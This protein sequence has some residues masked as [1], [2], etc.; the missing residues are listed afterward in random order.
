[1]ASE[2]EHPEIPE[3]DAKSLTMNVRPDANGKVAVLPA[4]E[5]EEREFEQLLSGALTVPPVPRTLLK[6]LDREI[7]AEWGVSPE[8]VT[9]NQGLAGRAMSRLRRVSVMSVSVAAL[10]VMIGFSMLMEN[11]Q[12]R[13]WAGLVSRMMSQGI[14]ELRSAESVRW[15]N[16]QAGIV[17]QEEPGLSTLVDVDRK[18][19]TVW[20]TG[21]GHSVI[22]QDS[23]PGSGLSREALLVGFLSG[24]EDWRQF[25]AENQ[26]LRAV[27]EQWIARAEGGG[28]QLSVQFAG[29]R[30]HALKLNL[31]MP[32]PSALPL[33]SELIDNTRSTPESALLSYASES[34]SVLRRLVEQGTTEHE[35][36]RTALQ[37]EAPVATSDP[38]ENSTVAQHD[39]VP[40]MKNGLQIAAVPDGIRNAPGTLVAAR[41]LVSDPPAQWPAVRKVPAAPI[42]VEVEKLN[43]LMAE[44]WR[45]N[46][47]APVRAATDDEMLRRTYLD[48]AGRIPTVAEVRDFL[49]DQ[50]P[51]RY[52]RLINR[53]LDSPDHA[54]HLA[55]VW[56]SF[57]IPEGVDLSVFGGVAAFD[58]WLA[59][60][61]E[62]NKPYNEVVSDLLLA[63]GR[64][65]RSGPLLFYSAV[66]LNPEELAARTSRVFL[67]MRLECAQC[68]DHPFEPWTQKDFWGMAAFF[69]QI[70][71]PKGELEAV[72][73]VMRVSDIDRGEVMIPEFDLVVKPHYLGERTPATSEGTKSRRQL[74]V[75]WLANA[76]NPYFARATVN[77]VWGHLFGRGIVDPI[78]DF[79]TQH[80]PLSPEL[81]EQ[82]AERF[83]ATNF[84]LRDLVRTIVLSRPYRL[85]SGADE[86]NETR[87]QWFAQ[88]TVKTLTAAQMYDCIS[89]ATMLENNVP[90][91]ARV[92]TTNRIG[93]N[94]RDQFIQEFHTP[95]GQQTDYHAGIPQALTL[96]NGGLIDGAT[97]LARSG[98][99]SSLEAPFFSDQERLEIL[100]LATLSRLPRDDERLVFGE[101]I[102]PELS[103]EE[104][105][106]NF[107]DLLW[108]LLN[109]AE[110][111]M[112]H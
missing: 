12:C 112:N 51:N 64:L 86:V 99:L 96:M 27:E 61:F 4:S 30:S 14:V 63:E 108:A 68:H 74:L 42:S 59:E 28:G 89:V 60:E 22:R 100:F 8:L 45:T 23:L 11:P 38:G 33:A 58:R 13:A 98:L 75:D 43:R 66:K 18:V 101:Y 110:F 81:L 54:S 49:N 82:L 37:N 111:T 104:K 102:R 10:L 71:R 53:L 52:E 109:S 40:G 85:T 31:T 103:D 67:G 94:E 83:V 73:T 29:E 97:G 69:A 62:A 3:D 88:M 78:D 48:L 26:N 47:V 2:F 105:R 91:S 57:L 72:S 17:G 39:A 25:A 41:A 36:I 92:L 32:E 107:A 5:A 15:L 95:A 76:E 19:V 9:R 56:R 35:E 6:R 65:S 21:V 16:L 44:L 55:A 90:G 50:S 79:G 87:Q 93:N 24:A 34:K 80:K 70:S 46:N 84:D 77:R 7:A 106:E 1:M 20:Q